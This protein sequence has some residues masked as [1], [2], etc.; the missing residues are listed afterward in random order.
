M[1]SFKFLTRW[2]RCCSAIVAA[3]ASGSLLSAAVL[4]YAD[5]GR[6][7]WFDEDSGLSLV[8]KQCDRLKA[9]SARH[10]CLRQ[11]AVAAASPALA[12]V[13]LDRR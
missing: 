12:L 13:A 1:K 7:P 10:Q 9:S 6:T 4:V 5:D 8:A 11:V 2:E 3:V